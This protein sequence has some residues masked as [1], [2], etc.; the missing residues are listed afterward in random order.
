MTLDASNISDEIA[1]KFITNFTPKERIEV[2]IIVAGMGMLNKLND[3][4][5][6][7][8][9]DSAMEIASALHEYTNEFDT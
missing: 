5:R 4:L 7:S 9:D 6:I 8:V 2:A 1:Q 3:S